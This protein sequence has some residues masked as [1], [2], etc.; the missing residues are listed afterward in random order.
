MNITA[1]AEHVMLA[2]RTM[3]D[4]DGRVVEQPLRLL[5]DV[6]GVKVSDARWGIRRLD[7]TEAVYLV[8]LPLSAN[9][10]CLVLLKPP[11]PERRRNFSG[12]PA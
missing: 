8:R 1:A 3:A 12:K 7:R 6:A 4:D 11:W 2:L 9:E 10:P 5:A